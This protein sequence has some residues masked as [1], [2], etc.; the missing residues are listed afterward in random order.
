MN[1]SAEKYSFLPELRFEQ[2]GLD[3]SQSAVNQNSADFDGVFIF[4]DSFGCVC[5]PVLSLPR[6]DIVVVEGIVV[7][8]LPKSVNAFIPNKNGFVITL[9]GEYCRFADEFGVGDV[10]CDIGHEIE[11]LPDRYVK[12]GDVVLGVD[13]VNT[14]RFPG[15]GITLYTPEYGTHTGTHPFFAEV[16]IDN[17]RVK[18]I[19]GGNSEIPRDGAV[20]CLS[21]HDERYEEIEKVSVGDTASYDIT[22]KLYRVFPLDI[23]GYNCDRDW[24]DLIIYDDGDYTGT[25]EY[26]FEL[27][28]DNNGIVV[29]CD[30]AG[31]MK[32]PEGG[33]VISGHGT[34]RR[35]LENSC[36]LGQNVLHDKENKKL[37]LFKTPALKLIEAEKAVEDV[38]ISFDKAKSLLLNIDYKN[39]SEGINKLKLGVIGARD[40]FGRRELSEAF[41][42]C[43]EVIEKAETLTYAMIESKTAENRAVWYR[44]HEQSDEAVRRTL[45]RMKDMHVNTLYLETWYEGFCIGKKIEMEGITTHEM[46]ADYDALEGFIRIGHE[47]GIEIHAWVHNF[48]VG[49]YYDDGRNYYNTYF[50]KFK[51]K[52]LI[53]CKGRD[54]FYYA[55]NNNK[56]IFLNIND[57]ECRDMMLELYR[58][59]ITGYELDGLHL[60]YIRLPELNYGG[61]DFGYNDDI[62]ADFRSATGIP[63]DPR[64]FKNASDVTNWEKWVQFRC[65]I[66]SSFASEVFDLVR[67]EKPDIWL[68][69]ATYPEIEFYKYTIMQDVKSF[70]DKEIFDEVF[71]MSYGIDNRAVLNSV[72]GYVE[73]T[74]GKTFYTAGLA[75]FLETL[76]SNFAKQLAEVERAGADGVS[77]FSLSSIHPKHYQRQMTEG[78]FRSPSVQVTRLSETVSAQMDFVIEKLYNLSQISDSL[79]SKDLIENACAVLKNKADSFDLN[80]ATANEKI[81]FCISADREIDDLIQMI[82]NTVSDPA[83]ADSIASDLED[84]QYWLLLSK[85]RIEN[86]I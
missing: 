81:E 49:Y 6:R 9:V 61:D 8:L 48:F 20:I 85:R 60:D 7:E 62:I 2:G 22:S 29:C 10:V 57:R 40:A 38:I 41:S 67:K 55:V 75:A 42:V 58:Q 84:L 39:I 18:S 27:A 47:M 51:D 31:N 50:D 11:S 53:D 70:V 80:N 79:S 46:N 76:P 56:F 15:A 44:S 14:K 3:L 12:L 64:T 35:A 17:G 77:V 78:A 5:T 86:R 54:Y 65:D 32:I 23:T 19:G 73:A 34:S 28:V 74:K 21:H 43:A 24:H 45:Q 82:H 68:T 52:Y 71:S 1:M 26:G 63:D 59:L 25:N 16:V 13:S 30:H 37:Y 83:V 4:D 69:A 66:I 33:Y 72:N 36:A